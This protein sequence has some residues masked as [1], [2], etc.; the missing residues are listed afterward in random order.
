MT[1]ETLVSIAL[2]LAALS[3][4]VAIVAVFT[5]R[6]ARKQLVIF[7]GTASEEDVLAAGVAQSERVDELMEKVA[8]LGQSVVVAQRDIA[9]SLRHLAVVRFNATGD[10]GGQ[11]SFSLAI[12]DDAANG[13]VIT[14]IQ[15]HNSG[16]IYSKTIFDGKSET[17]LSPEETQAIANARP[18]E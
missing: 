2:G 17:A 4:L 1:N 16:R 11:F 12:L 10:I 15:G 5:A 7:R 14:S 3:F 9:A 6:K 18:K 13:I 8:R